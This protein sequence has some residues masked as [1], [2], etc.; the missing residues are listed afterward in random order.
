MLVDNFISQSNNSGGGDRLVE[1]AC[2]ESH[3]CEIHAYLRLTSI[4]YAKYPRSCHQINQLLEM[5][6]IPNFCVTCD[7]IRGSRI[8]DD[9]NC[10]D[11]HNI[12]DLYNQAL[13][14]ARG[15]Q[16]EPCN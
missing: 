2:Y 4:V 13:H 5:L 3:E 11:G 7:I 15:L 6:H 16:Y 14:T 10:S 1:Y 12:N 8:I 9:H